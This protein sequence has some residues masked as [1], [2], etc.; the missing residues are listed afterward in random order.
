MFHFNHLAGPIGVGRYRAPFGQSP[1]ARIIP[2]GREEIEFIIDG[3]G[4]FDWEGQQYT[5]RCGT[6]LWHIPGEETIYRNN[7]SFPYECLMLLFPVHGVPKRQVAKVTQWTDTSAVRQFA[8]EL[9]RD[10]HRGDVDKVMLGQYVYTRMCWHAYEDSLRQ[11][12]GELP[13]PVQLTMHLL[14]TQFAKPLHIAEVADQVGVSIAHLHVLFKAHLGISPYQYLLQQ[15]LQEARRLLASGDQLV[16][17]ISYACGFQD[18][19]NFCRCFKAH[20][21]VSPAGYRLR[22]SIPR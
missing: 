4:Y 15:R 8:M 2:P 6:V 16:K 9:L 11:P 18:V 21:D 17:E 3:E 20:F 13:R 10:Y 19:V 1:S 22:N 12:V 5:A 14:E 7:G